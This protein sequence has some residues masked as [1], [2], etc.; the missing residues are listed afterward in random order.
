MTAIAERMTLERVTG[1]KPVGIAGIVLGV[2]ATWISLPPI[3]QRTLVWPVVLGVL[4]AAA[5]AYAISGGRR[6][7]GR[8]SCRER[9]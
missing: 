8:A 5:G 1:A 7:I 6:R 3:M 2:A 4:A 9:V